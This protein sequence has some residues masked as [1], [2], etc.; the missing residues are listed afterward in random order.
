VRRYASGMAL[1]TAAL[2][3]EVLSWIITVLTPLAPVLAVTGASSATAALV[4]P[5]MYFLA[6]LS[7]LFAY[8]TEHA[9]MAS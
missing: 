1:W 3:V 6:A 2:Q 7:V 4:A 9:E 5:P 8:V